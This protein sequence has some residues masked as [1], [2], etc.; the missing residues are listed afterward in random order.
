[1]NYFA[2]RLQI[3]SRHGLPRRS[4]RARTGR[5]AFERLEPRCLLAGNTL[6]ISEFMASNGLTLLDEDGDSSDWIEIH[7]PTNDPIDMGG[8]WLTDDQ[9]NPAKW[10]LPSQVLAPDDYQLVFASGKDRVGS[11]LHTN[12]KLDSDGEYLALME[13]D[14]ETIAHEF[15]PEYP[16]QFDDISY[17][18]DSDPG[19][20][21]VAAGEELRYLV[22]TAETLPVGWKDVGFDDSSWTSLIEAPD[23]LITEAGTGTPDYF[24]IQNVSQQTIDTTGWVVA[25]NS[26]G[27]DDIND[28]HS[29]L[30]SFPEPLQ[31]GEIAYREDSGPEDDIFWRANDVGWVMI[32][33]ETGEVVDFVVW[34]YSALD[35]AS[36]SVTIDP[37]GPFA[38]G[39][40]WNGPSVDPGAFPTGS[41]QR[42][43]ASEHDNASDWSFGYAGS[44]DLTNESLYLPFTLDV[45][46]GVGFDQAGSGVEEAIQIDIGAEMHGVNSTMLLRLP[47][48]V[49][50]PDSLSSFVL[51]TKYN[52]GFVAYINGFEVARRN[53]PAAPNGN[54][55]ATASRS[56][57]DSIQWMEFDLSNSVSLLT[58]GTNILTVQGLNI[59]AEDDTFLILT[60]L[61]G[62]ALRYYADPTPGS[63][64]NTEGVADFVRD[65]SFSV[66]RGFFEQ[67][68]DVIITTDTPNATIRY[69]LDGSKPT[70]TD[71]STYSGPIHISGTTTLRAFAYKDGFLPTNVDTHT[72]IF[73]DQVILQDQDS[74]IQPRSWGVYLG[75]AG[76]ANPGD[77][78]PAN[79]LMDPAI[80]EDP[81][82]S[83]TIKD[84]LKAIPTLSLVLDPDDLF[85]ATNGLYSN[86][87]YEGSLFE[88]A[89]SAE[90]FDGAGNTLFQ[91]DTGLRVH[92]GASRWPYAGALKHG[93]RL[94]FKRDY[95]P[96][97]L[98]Y[99]L[100]GNDAVDRF[101]T[102]VL[103]AGV[104]DLW[105]TNWW[106]TTVTYLYDQFVA[107]TQNA[108]GSLTH[109]GT[110]FHVYLNGLYWGVYNAV[111]RPDASFAASYYGGEKE[112]Y[113]CIGTW[114]LKD[115]NWDA[116]NDFFAMIRQPLNYETVKAVL[117][118][119]DFIDYL[120]A[121][122]FSGNYDWPQNNWYAT[123]RRV[124]GEKWHFHSWDAEASLI[125][126]YTNR[127]N[128]DGWYWTGGPGEVYLAL[129]NIAEFRQD[130]ADRV[131]QHMF[132]DGPLTVEANQARF[133]EQVAIIDRAI[134]GESARWGDSSFENVNPARTRDDWL[135]Q[136]NWTLDTYF[137]QRP[138]QILQQWRNVGLY[139]TLD[140]PEMNQHGGLIEAGFPLMLSNPNAVGA[141]Y[142][143][144]DGSD[145]RMPGGALSPTAEEFTA[146]IT[147]TTLVPTGSTWKYLDDGSDQDSVSGDWAWYD[148]QFDD[149]S[150]AA[151]PA[152]LGY[153][154]GDEVTTLDYGGDLNNKYITYYFRQEFEVSDPGQFSELTLR[155]LKDDGA[156]VY[157]NGQE[158]VRSNMPGGAFDYLTLA[159]AAAVEGVF[160]E[161][162]ISVADLVTGTNVLAVEVHQVLPTSS[163]ISFDLNLVGLFPITA[164][165]TIVPED[166]VWRYLDDGSDQGT[167]WY[168]TVF[169]DGSWASG[170]AE[171]GYG[172][173]DE[174]TVIG[175]GPDPADRYITSYFRHEFTVADPTQYAGAT[176]RLVRDDGAVVYLNG[177][178]IIR[179]NMP[180]GE[181]NHLTPASS[182]V[183]VPAES[184]FNE[185]VLDP[186]LLL[187]GNNVLAVEVHQAGGNSADVSMKL[188]L[189]GFLP[190]DAITLDE[191]TLVKTRVLD[192]GVWSALHEA[193]FIVAE[194]ATVENL[195]LTELNYNPH[196]PSDAENTAG[197][198]NGG[199]F[200]FIELQNTGA[201]PIDLAGLQFVDGINFDFTGQ[202]LTQLN[203]GEYVVVAKNPT[204]FQ[205]RYGTLA[206][207]LGPYNENL[208]NGGESIVVENILGDTLLSF[209]YGD[210]E[211]PG[212]PDRAD[213]NGATLELINPAGVPWT[214]PAR[215]TYLNDS[216]NWHSSGEYLGT[217]GAA[218]TGHYDGVV[219]NEVL[220]HTDDPLV[221]SIELHNPTGE[222]IPVGG[223]W[224]SDSNGDMLKFQIPAGVIVPAGGYIVFYE[225]HYDEGGLLAFD[226]INE[227]GGNDPVKDFALNGAKGEDVWMLKDDGDGSP[228]KFVDHVEFGAGLNG[229]SFGRWPDGSG[230]L[231]P[232][233]SRTLGRANSSPRIG[234]DLIISEVMFHPPDSGGGL[235]PQDREFIEIYNT[236]SA[237][238]SLNQWR[239]RKGLDFDFIPG[240]TLAGDE[241]LVVVSFDPADVV[242]LAAFR[243][244]YGIDPAVQI[245]GGHPD[246]LD[247][248]DDW[249]QL[250]RPDDPP[251][252]DPLYVPHPLEDEV[253]Y[254]D[255][256][257]PSTDGF[258]D[259][260]HRIGS[261][262]WGR[263][264]DSW[265]AAPPTPG[266]VDLTAELNE[267][268]VFYDNSR[269]DNEAKGGSDPTAVAPDKKALR[270][271]QIATFANYSSYSKGINGVIVDLFDLKLPASVTVADMAFH[272]GNDNTPGNWGLAPTPGR[273]DVLP[274]A[275]A[276]GSDR[277]VL[278]WDDN[279]IQNTW[280]EI[281]VL[282]NPRTGLDADAKFYFGH[283]AGETGNSATDAQVDASD[284]FAT[285]N[286]RHAFWDPAEL[287]DPYDFNRDRRVNTIDTLIA[288]NNQSSAGTELQL[289]DLSAQASPAIRAA[290]AAQ[291]QARDAVFQEL[292]VV[293]EELSSARF[294]WLQEIESGASVYKR[295]GPGRS[296]QIAGY[297]SDRAEKAIDR[298][299]KLE[300]SGW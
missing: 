2:K 202:G 297:G 117:D 86:P 134:V 243:A 232:M 6:Q 78:V 207:V 215:T 249:V 48:G 194:I 34:G 289:I 189:T 121:N 104:I 144:T 227:F 22:P 270:P 32:L 137:P 197:F 85:G 193:Q 28:V 235:L 19:L 268:F 254:D 89:A 198:V 166:S 111:E 180:A 82:Y 281:T 57:V 185:F 277:I 141:I 156:V 112:E 127:V 87:Q 73:L 126:I 259:S 59:S 190:G 200:E 61:E 142:Y 178:E 76:W 183:P 114:E 231:V 24:E 37:H 148:P 233:I 218:G 38:L 265:K 294:A 39:E 286:N 107:D 94:M 106:P 4:K 129:L 90:L 196:S 103:R 110:W 288:R 248:D 56:P 54:S 15:A 70:L 64:N 175:Y 226:P 236:T 276:L 188:E 201:Q 192:V 170:P 251:A 101:D 52:D 17:G 29:P 98:E 20:F 160:D 210:S 97:K 159:S 203:P 151:G 113:D 124:D 172:D 36:F 278:G 228:L 161:F 1:M 262:R 257:Y 149:N 230:E 177:Q 119:P 256:W 55:T 3:D 199:D 132:N 123:R 136:V 285:R 72:Y 253:E 128:Y 208:D 58:E 81:R 153:G 182:F 269:W 217:P 155:L 174:A 71:G 43:G 229:E 60:D 246:R 5:L 206:N 186:S 293:E 83:G 225:G 143:T 212:W 68:I 145:P 69:T 179:S 191:S 23:V 173:G 118:I 146:E 49:S 100:F 77:P 96:T 47:F 42:V 65:T 261:N 26:A 9:S 181:I 140:A 13:P 169:D 165:T 109:H 105:G 147:G 216:D 66:D 16:N 266:M 33:D 240:T 75:D 35:M 84:D 99:P 282:A 222:D 214:D 162:S 234:P 213:G 221:D 250:Q 220:T 157:L 8:W 25:A 18:V 31:P 279:T 284:V 287:D 91:S 275:G 271:G 184:Q 139:S 116:W 154:D 239:L 295:L 92:G 44:P 150:W 219:V 74:S 204:A 21:A 79:Y 168:G 300:D 171:L 272:I 245:I 40:M 299:L 67:P 238:V 41:L 131:Y 247:N 263:Q 283:A 158:V 53:A 135:N 120:I 252:N 115:G 209:T 63:E 167:A 296:S 152:Q 88:R 80:V 176:L 93:L 260:L 267:P 290:G 291:M 138:E 12:F 27:N 108:M 14:R 280:L 195:A 46:T 163:D 273:V 125:D 255:V 211:D 241:A 237:T 102:I 224:L 62:T 30:W 187:A 11:E 244:H 7:N 130:F 205:F 298:L 133:A 51:R 50:S 164:V 45:G 258:G 122:Q 10:S 264:A 274:D 223:W 242:K 95:G 292:E